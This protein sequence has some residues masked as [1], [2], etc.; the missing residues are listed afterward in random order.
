MRLMGHFMR[1]HSNSYRTLTDIYWDILYLI[2][3]LQTSKVLET[4]EVLESRK[5]KPHHSYNADGG[6]SK[7]LKKHLGTYMTQLITNNLQ[8]MPHYL[9]SLM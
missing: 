6:E 8:P 1:H 9:L 3:T 7:N 2:K 4:L 5:P